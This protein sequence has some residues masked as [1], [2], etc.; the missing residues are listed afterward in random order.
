MKIIVLIVNFRVTFKRVEDLGIILEIRE[1]AF[2]ERLLEGRLEL[3]L[4]V[5]IFDVLICS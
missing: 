4:L 5:E 1:D 2:E 3:V